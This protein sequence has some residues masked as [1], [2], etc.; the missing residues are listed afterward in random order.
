MWDDMIKGAVSFT[1]GILIGVVTV[2][3]LGYYLTVAFLEQ[4]ALAASV[5]ELK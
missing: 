3:C 2:Y 4:I 5:L 1:L